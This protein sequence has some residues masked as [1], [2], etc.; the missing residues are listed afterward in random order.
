MN[1]LIL[2]RVSDR[3]PADNLAKRAGNRVVK[4]QYR[5]VYTMYV[6]MYMNACMMT[7]HIKCSVTSLQQIINSVRI[8][9]SFKVFIDNLKKAT[10]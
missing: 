2:C 8:E 9:S 5:H 3:N 10:C 4:K 6:C 7:L 1:D